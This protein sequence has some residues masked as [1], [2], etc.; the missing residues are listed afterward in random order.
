M[1][2]HFRIFIL[3]VSLLGNIALGIG[4][5]I[6]H[7]DFKR[8]DFNK[9]VSFHDNNSIY[10]E[11]PYSQHHQMRTSIFNSLGCSDGDVLVFG[12]RHI[13]LF[14]WF[15]NQKKLQIINRAIQ[16]E[17]FNSLAFHLNQSIQCTPKHLILN[18]G[19]N[20]IVHFQGT[21]DSLLISLSKL[22]QTI[23]ANPKIKSVIWIPVLPWFPNPTEEA[24]LHRTQLINSFLYNWNSH[25][26][27]ILD[28]SEP[29]A[30]S[31]TNKNKQ[32]FAP[33]PPPEIYQ[34]LYDKVTI[35]LTN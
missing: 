31:S 30:L 35:T 7:Y 6:H 3:V 18:I 5:Y 15:G 13:E 20:D 9:N 12:D 1:K 28:I 21:N 16:D 17:T 22:L 25:K 2:K 23:D 32:S 8:L 4:W 26:I 34:E 14:D 11:Y 29:K 24:W 27:K 10:T 19:H 33:Y